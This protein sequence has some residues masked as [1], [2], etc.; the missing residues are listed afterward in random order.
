MPN[1][2]Y[3]SESWQVHN[4]LVYRLNAKKK[5]CAFQLLLFVDVEIPCL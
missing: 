4:K 3:A 5:K 2:P 1:E